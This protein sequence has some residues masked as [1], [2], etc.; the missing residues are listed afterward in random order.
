MA[1]I[2]KNGKQEQP[3][4]KIPKALN[5]E[6]QPALAALKKAFGNRPEA[7]DAWRTAVDCLIACYRLHDQ[8]QAVDEDGLPATAYEQ[9]GN[10]EIAAAATILYQEA[11]VAR[12]FW[13]AEDVYYEIRAQTF[14]Q[15][16]RP[17]VETRE[18]IRLRRLR[19]DQESEFQWRDGRPNVIRADVPTAERP[20][21]DR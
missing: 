19:P 15:I 21:N 11:E 18:P 6:A 17:L 1:K 14:E 9:A 4:T 8:G 10:L 2:P 5:D 3:S 12:T 7:L 13:S 16:G 20:S